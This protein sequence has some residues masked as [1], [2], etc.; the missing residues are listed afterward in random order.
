MSNTIHGV[1]LSLDATGLP[2]LA[3]LP[4]LELFGARDPASEIK[5]QWRSLE[6]L[7]VLDSEGRRLG[8]EQWVFVISSSLARRRR[9]AHP[10]LELRLL[11]EWAVLH[12]AAQHL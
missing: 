6:D 4:A 7:R 9:V 1:Y 5:R 11:C 8:T 3:E 2:D 10:A 12:L